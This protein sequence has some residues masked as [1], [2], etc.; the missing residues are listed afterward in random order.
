MERKS[1]KFIGDACKQW[2]DT[3]PSFRNRIYLLTRETDGPEYDTV[4]GL[5][6]IAFNELKARAFVFVNKRVSDEPRADW[7]DHNKVSC[8]LIGY[9]DLQEQIV[10]T[11]FN[12]G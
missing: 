4:H 7:L 3:I 6:V 2:H 11:D 9:S 5:V 1:E 12:A 10:L 8:R